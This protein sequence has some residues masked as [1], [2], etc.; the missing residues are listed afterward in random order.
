[1]DAPGQKRLCT[2]SLQ[3][4]ATNQI[5]HAIKQLLWH[6]PTKLLVENF[7]QHIYNLIIFVDKSFGQKSNSNSDRQKYSIVLLTQCSWI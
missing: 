6:E 4:N 3:K 2:C 1:M 7:T 5:S